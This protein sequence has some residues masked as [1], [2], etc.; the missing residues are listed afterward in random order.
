MADKK[1]LDFAAKMIR[2]TKKEQY[3][4]K[5]K[6]NAKENRIEGKF[7]VKGT[8]EWKD[9][10]EDVDEIPDK[11]VKEFVENREPDD[12]ILDEKET[13]IEL[14]GIS[15]QKRLDKTKII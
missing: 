12:Y 1:Q 9:I 10:D 15:E 11:K 14:L 8:K 6:F 2:D 13:L 7:R 4:T 5:V 3:Q